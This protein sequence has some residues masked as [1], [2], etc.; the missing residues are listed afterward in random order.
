MLDKESMPLLLDLL[1]ASGEL[2]D[3][4]RHEPGRQGRAGG[5]ERSDHRPLPRPGQGPR[6][7]RPVHDEGR[8]RLAQ[9]HQDPQGR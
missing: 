7:A 1:E 4:P 8:S 3:E 5:H 6:R 9:L 2:D